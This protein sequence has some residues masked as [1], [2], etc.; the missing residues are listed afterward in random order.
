MF[1]A[2]VPVSVVQGIAFGAKKVHVQSVVYNLP[3]TVL[4]AVDINLVVRYFGNG[5]IASFAFKI[6]ELVILLVLLV[7]VPRLHFVGRTVL[8]PFLTVL[9]K[10]TAVVGYKCCCLCHERHHACNSKHQCQ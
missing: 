8:Y 9:Q 4:L 1:H 10:V 7:F 3:V 2:V 6:E 5:N